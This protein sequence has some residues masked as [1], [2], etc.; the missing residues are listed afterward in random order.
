MIQY[1]F[2]SAMYALLKLFNEVWVTGKIPL[3]WKKAV[4]LPLLKTGKPHTL[5]NSYWP[6][7]LPS[8]LEKSFESIINVRLIFILEQRNLLDTNQCSFKMRSTLDHLVHLAHTIREVFIDKQ[9]CVVVFFDLK[10]KKKAY[11]TTSRFGILCDFA[12]MGMRGRMLYGLSDFL[13]Q[14]GNK[15]Q[16]A[17]LFIGLSRKWHFSGSHRHY[18]LA[19]FH[20]REW[21]T[22]GLYFKHNS[23]YRENEFRRNRNT[24]YCRA[25]CICGWPTNCMSL[26]QHTHLRK[27]D[28][29]KYKLS[30]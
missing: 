22:T 5:P 17:L 20:L 25:F 21:G 16:N 15:R 1:L 23:F 8:C 30:Q 24:P 18:L 14:Y 26:L 28:T 27:T 6:L 3:A 7:A 4:V 13:G 9:Q 19:Y 29:T 11:D 12:N 10:K 2:E